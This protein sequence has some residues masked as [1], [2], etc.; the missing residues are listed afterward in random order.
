MGN[1]DI[2]PYPKTSHHLTP[3]LTPFSEKNWNQ[4]NHIPP[5]HL[6]TMR[7]PENLNLP[8]P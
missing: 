2:L 3:N 4:R 1:N 7:S 5:H 6:R 8:M